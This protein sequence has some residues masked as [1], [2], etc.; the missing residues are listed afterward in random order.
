VA[1]QA[2]AR[3][4]PELILRRSRALFLGLGSDTPYKAHIAPLAEVPVSM[5]RTRRA[6]RHAAIVPLSPFSSMKNRRT[7]HSFVDAPSCVCPARRAHG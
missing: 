2:D 4:Q 7:R 6:R 1:E 5:E 3:N